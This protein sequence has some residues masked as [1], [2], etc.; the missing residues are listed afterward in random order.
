MTQCYERHIIE[1]QIL[2]SGTDAGRRS[3]DYSSFL[4][5]EFRLCA[6]GSSDEK[7]ST[8]SL[9]SIISS[10]VTLTLAIGLE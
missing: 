9:L 8:N 1:V 10:W 3:L 4:S 5:I 6:T 2:G 7:L